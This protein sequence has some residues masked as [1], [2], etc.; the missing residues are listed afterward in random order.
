[1]DGALLGRHGGPWRVC[2]GRCVCWCPVSSEAE[3][4]VGMGM[5]PLPP[6]PCPPGFLLPAGSGQGWFMGFSLTEELGGL[7]LFV[8]LF[9]HL[10]DT[11][12]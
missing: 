5:G 1:M 11:N 10:T 12:R 8:F 7:S 6:G 9:K 2:V 3:E 4:E